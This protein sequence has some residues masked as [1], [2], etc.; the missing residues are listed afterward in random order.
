MVHLVV[1]WGNAQP[2]KREANIYYVYVFFN[3][4]MLIIHASD[5]MIWFYKSIVSE[6]EVC[7][8]YQGFED[9]LF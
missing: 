7:F 6:I 3:K 2:H 9:A 5:W 1:V 8:C 4:I